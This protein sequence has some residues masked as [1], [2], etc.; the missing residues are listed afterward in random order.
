[1][2]LSSL[3]ELIE[4]FHRSN[5]LPVFLTGI[6]VAILLT[7]FVL[8][9]LRLRIGGPSGLTNEI[10]RLERRNAE[11][12]TENDR[13]RNNLR[14]AEND[15][16]A[17]KTRISE[18]TGHLNAKTQLLTDLTAECEHLKEEMSVMHQK[19]IVSLPCVSGKLDVEPTS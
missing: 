17:A 3:Y 5:Q 1:M 15:I 11:L 13:L 8:R 6:V 2:D 16:D 7:F 4:R 9:V 10:D 12:V 18:L 14:H 19:E